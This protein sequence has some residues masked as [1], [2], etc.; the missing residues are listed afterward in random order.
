MSLESGLRTQLIVWS[1]VYPV[2]TSFGLAPASTSAIASSKWPFCTAS[3]IGLVPRA[4]GR[5]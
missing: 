3:S 5:A 4:G 1:G 2:C